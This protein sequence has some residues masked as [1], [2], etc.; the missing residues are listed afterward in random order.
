MLR[1]TTEVLNEGLKTQAYE[2]LNVDM[3]V[4]PSFIGTIDASN[5]TGLPHAKSELII[6]G[7]VAATPGA[8]GGVCDVTSALGLPK[9]TAD[10]AVFAI[11]STLQSIRLASRT[12][13]GASGA[14]LVTNAI[15]FLFVFC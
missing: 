5:H 7:G 14:G 9:V 3:T 1:A 4:R 13:A 2:V 8:R 10:E 12:E 11:E 15:L 6:T